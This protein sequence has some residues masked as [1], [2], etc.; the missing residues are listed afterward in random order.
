MY[1]KAIALDPWNAAI[2][3]NAANMLSALS[4]HAEAIAEAEQALRLAPEAPSSWKA[5]AT[6]LARAGRAPEANAAMRRAQ[7]LAEAPPQRTTVARTM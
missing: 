2:R 4:R 1:Q 5:Y 7:Q 3:V 6:L